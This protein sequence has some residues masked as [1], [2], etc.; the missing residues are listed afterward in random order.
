VH[1]LALPLALPLPCALQLWR[2][3]RSTIIVFKEEE[4]THLV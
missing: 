4:E 3:E 2:K 1:L